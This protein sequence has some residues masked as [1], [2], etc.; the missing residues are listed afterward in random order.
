MFGLYSTH[1]MVPEDEDSLGTFSHGETGNIVK[2]QSPVRS[3]DSKLF[4]NPKQHLHPKK[5]RVP[6]VPVQT[7]KDTEVLVYE[8]DEEIRTLRALYT[9]NHY[10]RTDPPIM[11][12]STLVKNFRRVVK[13]E[14]NF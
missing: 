1:Y 11:C 13:R 3:T 12:V 7:L 10:W 9:S 14:R 2:K 5:I 4:L 8:E 6:S